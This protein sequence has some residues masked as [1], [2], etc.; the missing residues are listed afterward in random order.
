[1]NKTVHPHRRHR[2]NNDTIR[3]I[4]L[5]MTAGVS[6]KDS[7]KM[8]GVHHSFIRVV[9]DYYRDNS[10][11]PTIEMIGTVKNGAK[12]VPKNCSGAEHAAA[13]HR[14][15]LQ[16]QKEREE[17]RIRKLTPINPTLGGAFPVSRERLMGSRA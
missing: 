9:R 11:V 15:M 16:E 10:R 4:I 7:V 13:F 5:H 17:Q 3:Q 2:R 1:M 8:L 14:E 6:V 12:I